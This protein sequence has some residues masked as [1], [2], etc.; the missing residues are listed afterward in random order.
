M[1]TE[2]PIQPSEHSQNADTFLLMVRDIM[3]TSYPK[4]FV[5]ATN[6]TREDLE[7]YPHL[8]AEFKAQHKY[9]SMTDIQRLLSRAIQRA[10]FNTDVSITLSSR[11]I[12]QLTSAHRDIT[13]CAMNLNGDVLKE[14]AL[15]KDKMRER[16]T[17]T[18]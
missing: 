7:T 11:N 16:I 9:R 4:I 8:I 5:A 15:R 2:S 10:P 12:E 14:T 1:E 3:A 18:L 17:K 13:L 6:I